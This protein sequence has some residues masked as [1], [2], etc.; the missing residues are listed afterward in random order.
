[1]DRLAEAWRGAGEVVV[2]DWLA[3]LTVGEMEIIVFRD[4]R[5][6]V[7]GTESPAEAM[8]QFERYVR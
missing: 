6:V 3:S 8:A 7:K 4:G 5:G 1:M 2:N